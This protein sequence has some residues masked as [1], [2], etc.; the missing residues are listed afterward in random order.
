[1]ALILYILAIAA[2]KGS[3]LF[4]IKRLVASKLHRM[5][6]S[7]LSV[8]LAVWAIATVLTTALRC[9]LPHSWTKGEG[10]CLSIVSIFPVVLIS[11]VSLP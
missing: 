7:G 11:L 2:S 5:V 10:K 3:A 1:M 9:G 4:F 8:L 6:I